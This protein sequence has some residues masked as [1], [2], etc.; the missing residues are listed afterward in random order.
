M[1]PCFDSF[2]PGSHNRGGRR[3]AFGRICPARD[4]IDPVAPLHGDPWLWLLGTFA[5]LQLLIF[6]FEMATFVFG[7][8]TERMANT[9]FII[10]YLG[11]LPSFLSQTRWLF[12]PLA[13]SYA[14]A[15]VIFVPK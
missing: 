7:R 3:P 13:G 9:L 5:G 12:T 10:A 15:L 2:S 8:S 4:T 6:L 1:T 14:L 11:L